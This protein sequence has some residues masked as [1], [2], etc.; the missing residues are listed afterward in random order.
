VEHEQVSC[1]NTPWVFPSLTGTSLYLWWV[2]RGLTST[3]DTN[4]V[5]QVNLAKIPL[6]EA[7]LLINSLIF[8]A[9]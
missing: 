5:V 3:F 1:T 6:G 8:F 2:T 4:N 7:I 9:H